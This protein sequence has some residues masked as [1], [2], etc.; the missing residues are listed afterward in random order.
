MD[1]LGFVQRCINGDKASWDKF[2][3]RY[4]RLIYSYI[5][6]VIEAKSYTFAREHIPD[7]FQ[8]LFYS[9]IK[10]DFHKLKSYQGRN[11]CSLAS[12]LRQVTI[13]FTIDYLR[14]L[15]PMVSI[16][17]TDDQ[18]F[19]LKDV[20]ASGSPL[21][22]EAINLEDAIEQ[23]KRCILKLNN[24]ERY[25]LELHINRGVRL[26]DLKHIFNVSRGAVDMQKSRIIAKLKE[27]FHLAGFF[28]L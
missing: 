28:G 15:R 10:D 27:C 6:N 9:L 11:G 26:E 16:D 20:L 12:W 19:A 21:A 14:K 22:P 24:E 1:D 7:I 5:H 8:S 4:S 23:L 3:D 17:E 2:L 13:N 18:G 25:F